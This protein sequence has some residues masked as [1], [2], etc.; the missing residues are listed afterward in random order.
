MTLKQT[1]DRA[2]SRLEK[3]YPSNEARWMVR[4]IFFHLKGYR[5]ADLMLKSDDEV[6]DFIEG[7]VDG[8]VTRLLDHEPI[9]YVF[10][11][12]RF[13]GMDLKVT[14]D[15]LIPRPETEELVDIIVKHWSG[16]DDLRVLDIC[17]GSG[18][19]AIALS[20]NLPF[21]QVTA[22]DISDAA[23]KVARENADALKA[24]VDF[25]H[26]DALALPGPSGDEFDLIV[27][28]PPYVLESERKGM[29]KNVLDYEPAT[30]LFVPDND[31]LRF[32]KPI[33][34]Y[35]ARALRPGRMLYLEIN[36]LEVEGLRRLGED[37]AWSDCEI[38][39]D[40]S[41]RDRF[42]ILTKES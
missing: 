39:R 13:Y 1:M 7:K 19:I 22:L 15:T 33:I 34:A 23:L 14:P 18:C 42:M 3:V 6:S 17:T 27:S 36:P 37:A 26:A 38:V 16:K 40:I 12:A 35:S 32:Y 4:E 25:R 28:N 5:L 21:S 29:E 20:R 9:Q 41:G 30:A 11:D 10:G 8:I 2:Q 24:K 31:P